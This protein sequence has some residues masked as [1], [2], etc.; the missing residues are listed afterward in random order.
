MIKFGDVCRY[1]SKTTNMTLHE[2]FKG[3][4]LKPEKTWS[5]YAPLYH[6]PDKS[7]GFCDAKCSIEYIKQ[8]E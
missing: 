8:E 7:I 5:Y 2:F 1:C 3:T 4:H 6:I